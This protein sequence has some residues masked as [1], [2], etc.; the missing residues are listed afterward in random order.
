MTLVTVIFLDKQTEFKEKQSISLEQFLEW[1]DKV[2]N[3]ALVENW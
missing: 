2:L 3:D 1:Y